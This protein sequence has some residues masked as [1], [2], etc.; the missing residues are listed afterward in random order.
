MCTI[1]YGYS[2][3][4]ANYIIYMYR[5]I[6]FLT[7]RSAVT[8]QKLVRFSFAIEWF[9]DYFRNYISARARYDD[10]DSER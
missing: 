5:V 8:R 10:N 4:L 9:I 2:L 1:Y 7:T 3:I 6:Y